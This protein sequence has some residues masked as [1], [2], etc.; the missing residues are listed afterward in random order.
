M[1]SEKRKQKLGNGKQ[2]KGNREVSAT[3]QLKPEVL[4]LAKKAILNEE[5]NMVYSWVL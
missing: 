4:V 3:F 1:E 5:K 2:K